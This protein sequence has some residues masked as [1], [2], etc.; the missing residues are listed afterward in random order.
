MKTCLK[1]RADVESSLIKDD[2]TVLLG[3]FEFV[4][5]SCMGGLGLVLPGVLGLAGPGGL[6]WL[7]SG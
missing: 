5:Y 2:F 1:I 7:G 4:R 3:A 6:V